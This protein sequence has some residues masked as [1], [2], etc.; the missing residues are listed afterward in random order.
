MASTDEYLYIPF[1]NGIVEIEKKTGKPIILQDITSEFGYVNVVNGYI[2]YN[3]FNN[4]ENKRGLVVQSLDGKFLKQISKMSY[5]PF[6]VF[7]EWIYATN[8]R[9]GDLYKINIK[10]S[11]QIMLAEEPVEEF[12]LHEN[13]IFYSDGNNL[14]SIN[15]DG[16]NKQ[17]LLSG[18]K[19]KSITYSNKDNTLLFI[20]SDEENGIYSYNI[21]TNK[22]TDVREGDYTFVQVFENDGIVTLNSSGLLQS[23]SLADGHIDFQ[24]PEVTNFQIFND[25]LYY[26]DQFKTVY[27]ITPQ[28][29]KPNK[30]Y[31][32][33]EMN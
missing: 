19:L 31:S 25:T 27:S 10:N 15:L 30:V 11:E 24:I 28:N 14:Y 23:F 22:L 12:A 4:N 8:L 21:N 1:E 9:G 3:A 6:V 18:I 32:L 20:N 33:R 17:K 26:F 29:N 5:F 7:G 2:F 16:E 13:G